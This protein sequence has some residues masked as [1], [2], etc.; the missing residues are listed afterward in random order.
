MLAISIDALNPRALAQLGPQRAPH[1]HRMIAEGAS[2]MNARTAFESTSTLPNHTG[3]VTGRRVDAD[4]GGHGVT[5]NTDVPGSRVQEA[6][7]H[8][9]SSVFS[10]VHRAGGSTALFATESKFSL[11]ERS[12][13]AGIDRTTIRPGQDASVARAARRDFVDRDR[14]LSFVHL[15]DVDTVGHAEGGMSPAYLAAVERV[16]ALVGKFL[17]TLARHPRIAE[18]TIVV[19]TADHGTRARSHDD[20]TIRANFRVPFIVWGPG[21]E[22]GDLYADETDGYHPPGKARPPYDGQQPIR[23]GDLANLTAALLGLDPVPGSEFGSEGT[24]QVRDT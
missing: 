16:D 18:R 13:P 15:G 3:M 11:F 10:V 17:G 8:P 4:Q 6:A 22:P 12:W 20:E 21:V 24:L 1:L 5:F 14:T 23:N 19:L 2:T 7:G 9:V